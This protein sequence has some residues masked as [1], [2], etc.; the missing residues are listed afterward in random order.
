MVLN[1][2]VE[3]YS[4][5]VI[6][7]HTRIS[8]DNLEALLEGNCSKLKRVQAFGFISI[9]EREYGIDLSAL[10]KE[11]KDYFD[12]YQDGKTPKKNK[13]ATILA[14]LEEDDE[15][16]K[17]TK[18]IK[19][20]LNKILIAL[21]V[22]VVAYGSWQLFVPDTMEMEDDL[23][24]TLSINEETNS[25]K[26][27]G[28]FD[29]VIGIFKSDVIE[30][31][32]QTPAPTELVT[33]AWDKKS[34]GNDNKK[35]SKKESTTSNTKVAETKPKIEDA[36]KSIEAKIIEQV[37]K[38]E[39]K[40]AREEE[41]KNSGEDLPQISDLI[42]NATAGVDDLVDDSKIDD[43]GDNLDAEVPS[44]SDMENNNMPQEPEP[45]QKKTETTNGKYRTI[46]FHPRSKV[47]V[48][49]T[50]L[51]TM[52][53][54]V[55]TGSKDISLNLSNGDSYIVATGHGRVEFLNGQKSVLK[56]GDGK[57][58]FF[59]V[60]KNGVKEISHEEFQRLNKSKVW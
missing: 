55:V 43:G 19:A 48:G 24:G 40:K 7:R 30:E 51:K 21:F 59:K 52:K 31:E 4:L 49:Y 11:C 18:K 10:R 13:E 47:W 5:N 45:K 29:S 23:N 12:A 1:E 41:M 33:G 2:L 16:Q 56:L 57:K 27:G 58:H 25:S 36:Q 44:M 39:I 54:A 34:N 32:T 46:T 38:E 22:V 15:P 14:S 9:L 8:D 35:E 50:N 26:G 28:F 42:S 6:S 60:T 3:R 20:Y 53:R 37:K 17:S